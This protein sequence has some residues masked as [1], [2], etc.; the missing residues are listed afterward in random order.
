MDDGSV[1][2]A[3]RETAGSAFAFD[4]A[5]ACGSFNAIKLAQTEEFAGWNAL[6]A[7]GSSGL[8]IVTS[9]NVAF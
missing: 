1:E 5:D 3:D 9:S 8:L 2:V 6:F 7:T 4:E